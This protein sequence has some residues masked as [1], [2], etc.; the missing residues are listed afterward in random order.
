MANVSDLRNDYRRARDEYNDLVSKT[1]SFWG[2]FDMLVSEGLDTANP[3]PR[4]YVDQAFRVLN[5]YC[6]SYNVSEYLARVGGY[7][8]T[9]TGHVAISLSD[10]H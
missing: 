3:T 9:D 2:E 4:D 1:G 7:R 6:D 5:A 10:L 8:L